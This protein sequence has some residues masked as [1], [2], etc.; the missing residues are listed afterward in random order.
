MFKHF[1]ATALNL[2]TIISS[3]PRKTIDEVEVILSSKRIHKSKA[4]Y[5]SA[6]TS[7]CPTA[8]A[9]TGCTPSDCPSALVDGGGICGPTDTGENCPTFSECFPSDTGCGGVDGP[10]CTTQELPA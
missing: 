6:C 10:I 1:V 3:N 2:V 8:L 9:D 4:G 5:F 7:D